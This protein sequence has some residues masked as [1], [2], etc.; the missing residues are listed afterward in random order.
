MSKQ[1]IKRIVANADVPP[2]ELVGHDRNFRLHPDAQKA[3]LAGVIEDIGFIKSVIVNQRTGRII[4]G[5]LRVN[6]A[7]ESGQETIPVE[8]VDLTEAEELEALA[9]LDPLTTLAE[10]DAAQLDALL[11]DVETEQEAVQSLLADL[12]ASNPLPET[13]SAEAPQEFSEYGEDIA[14]EY[15]CPKCGYQWSGKPG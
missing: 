7:L 10:V 5:H 2:S 1:W 8:Y 12:A 4:D 3:A 15:C 6:L 14:T 11:R 13:G 9:T